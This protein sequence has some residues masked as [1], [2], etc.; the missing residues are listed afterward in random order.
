MKITT[1][2]FL[3]SLKTIINIDCCSHLSN[4]YFFDLTAFALM[5]F[6]RLKHLIK[7]EV[8]IELLIFLNLEVCSI[9]HSH[10]LFVQGK[11]HYLG[12]WVGFAQKKGISSVDESEMLNQIWDFRGQYFT[13]LFFA[14]YNLFITLE[15][16]CNIR[17][18]I[19]HIKFNSFEHNTFLK[20]FSM[21]NS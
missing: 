7:M 15:D 3:S 1:W 17:A 9:F 19:P 2:I 4:S 20:I 13:G 8:L 5:E 16:Y 12:C 6:W 10:L 14:N 18:A 21:Y 11:L